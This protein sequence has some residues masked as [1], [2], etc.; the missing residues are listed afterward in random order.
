MTSIGFLINDV[1]GSFESRLER[2]HRYRSFVKCFG[3]NITLY[4]TNSHAK[5]YSRKRIRVRY[6]N[7]NTT[8]TLLTKWHTRRYYAFES[9]VKKRS[10][11]FGGGDILQC[12]S[13]QTVCFYHHSVTGWSAI[14]N[15][16]DSI[17]VFCIE[18]SKNEQ[19]DVV[20]YTCFICVC[21]ISWSDFR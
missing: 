9:V 1:M 11:I 4:F 19:S 10:K 12:C 15:M 13:N 6:V 17:D 5:F 20:S 14:S 3:T 18:W 2:H 16:F 7:Y 8:E 21:Y